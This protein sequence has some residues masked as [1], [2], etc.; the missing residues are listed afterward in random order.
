[1][2]PSR[3]MRFTAAKRESSVPRCLSSFVTAVFIAAFAGACSN[4]DVEVNN[5]EI[6][7]DSANKGE[8]LVVEGSVASAAGLTSIELTVLDEEDAP[9]ADTVG[10]SVSN[11]ALRDDKPLSWDLRRDAEAKI[12]TSKSTPSGTYKLRVEGKTDKKNSIDVKTFTIR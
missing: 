3:S 1:M 8:S 7:P 10:I 5:L 6:R 11:N 12:V 4:A 2:S 9:L